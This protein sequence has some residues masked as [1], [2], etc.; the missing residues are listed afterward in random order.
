MVGVRDDEAAVGGGEVM[1]VG[2]GSVRPHAVQSAA[3]E[4]AISSS[5]VRRSIGSMDG[6]HAGPRRP[7][8]ARSGHATVSSVAERRQ[9]RSVSSAR[10]PS[11]AGKKRHTPLAHRKAPRCSPTNSRTFEPPESR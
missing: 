11:N 2:R 5:A 6:K 8:K 1:G 7:T 4:P 10:A 3:A 9:K